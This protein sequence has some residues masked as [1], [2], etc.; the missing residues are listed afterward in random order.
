MHF[1]GGKNASHFCQFILTTRAAVRIPTRDSHDSARDRC[2]AREKTT[3]TMHRGFHWRDLHWRALI[4]PSALRR[5]TRSASSRDSA[6]AVASTADIRA[7]LAATLPKFERLCVTGGE[8]LETLCNGSTQLVTDCSALL[9]IA[10]GRLDGQSLARATLDLLSGPLGYLDFCRD[11][12]ADLL[13]RLAAC[14]D[15]TRSMIEVRAR[16][17]TTLAPL[18]YMTVLFKI[19]SATLPEEFRET[20][21]NVT[22][23]IDRMRL[24]VDETFSK[25]AELLA[26]AHATLAR[27]RQSLEQDFRS[28]FAHIAERRAQ[29]DDAIRTLDDQLAQNTTRD[30][31]LCRQSQSIATEVSQIVQA[32]QFQ[33]IVQQKSDHVL[34][35]LDTWKTQ[36]PTQPLARLQ[37]LQLEG[38]ATDISTGQ[39]TVSNGLAHIRASIQRFDENTRQLDTLADMA[40]PDGM[41][42]RLLDAIAEVHAM[43]RGL[44]DTTAQTHE[45]IRPAGDLASSLSST[46]VELATNMR[47]IALNAQIRSVQIG[48]LT[49]LETLASRTASI[50]SEIDTV[51]EE[52]ARALEALRQDL[53][54]M[55]AT[56]DE[57]RRLAASQ[58]A[59]LD[60]ARPAAESRLH[61]LRERAATSQLAI[62]ASIEALQSCAR[63]FDTTFAALPALRDEI[64]AASKSLHTLAETL[65][66]ASAA[67][68]TAHTACYTMASEH[69]TAAAV[70]ATATATAGTA[71][72]SENTPELFDTA[73]PATSDTPELFSTEDSAPPLD[74]EPAT[75]EPKSKTSTP[76]PSPAPDLGANVELF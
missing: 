27:V 60:A 24:L 43:T 51:S 36:P 18:T 65:P 3:L 1:P 72:L 17:H 9:E 63:E 2:R 25:N 34:S 46:L 37:A 31:D 55:F 53:D 57:F 70:F 30:A 66:A 23:E 8:K 12:H 42:K 52:S 49:G 19:E 28:R 50:S 11:R 26:N 35:A 47:L 6:L 74:S 44:A 58:I 33:D 22:T 29:I 4:L 39:Q 45:A 20:F 62:A 59:A 64:A 61:T 13:S 14:E 32:L 21:H 10:G 15:R 7:R 68:L 71:D 75:A 41:V 54:A 5:F 48:E 73:P 76:A 38:V 67:D 69:A 40:S 16:M 56:F